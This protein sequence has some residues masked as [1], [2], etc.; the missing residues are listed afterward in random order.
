MKQVIFFLRL[1][2]WF[3]LR[4]LFRYRMRT[5]IVIIGIALGASVFT[6]VR[7]SIHATLSS[8]SNSMDRIA[9]RADLVAALPG[10]HLPE[11]LIVP[12]LKHPIIKHASPVLT[13]YAREDKAGSEPFLLVGIDP[14]LDQ[15]FRKW[16]LTD[17]LSQDSVDWLELIKTPFTLVVGHALADRLGWAPGGDIRLTHTHQSARFQ[18]VGALRPEGLALVEGGR[19]G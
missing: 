3:S 2:I 1:Y 9:G 6:S 7:L 18:I 4:H 16:T 13:T 19:V 8:F 14:I 5:L 15:S 10:G 11:N 12:L 17:G